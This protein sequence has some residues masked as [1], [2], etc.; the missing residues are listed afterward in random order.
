MSYVLTQLYRLIKLPVYPLGSIP[1]KISGMEFK[2]ERKTGQGTC[3]EK[4]LENLNPGYLERLRIAIVDH[5]LTTH[6]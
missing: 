4:V 6:T 3:N 5:M 1:K 2:A